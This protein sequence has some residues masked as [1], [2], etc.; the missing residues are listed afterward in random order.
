MYTYTE[1]SVT[2]IHNK[3]WGLNSVVVPSQRV[4]LDE[5]W[6]TTEH[7]FKTE[8]QKYAFEVYWEEYMI[9]GE[10]LIPGEWNYCCVDGKF[11]HLEKTKSAGFID[12][13]ESF[14]YTLIY[15][16]WQNDWLTNNVRL[17]GTINLT[18]DKELVKQHL[19]QT[20]PLISN[21]NNFRYLNGIKKETEPTSVILPDELSKWV[22][23]SK[24]SSY[25]YLLINDELK[26]LNLGEP[27]RDKLIIPLLYR[28][29][30]KYDWKWVIVR[31]L[32]GLERKTI[33]VYDVDQSNSLRRTLEVKFNTN[34][35]YT[36][37]TV[38]NKVFNYAKTL[39]ESKYIDEIDLSGFTDL[40]QLS[41]TTLSPLYSSIENTPRFS[42]RGLCEK[43]RSRL[44]WDKELIPQMEEIVTRVFSEGLGDLIN[45]EVDNTK[46]KLFKN[47]TITPIKRDITWFDSER[48]LEV[49][50][51]EWFFRFDSLIPY[52]KFYRNFIF[53]QDSRKDTDM[54]MIVGTRNI[55]EDVTRRSSGMVYRDPTTKTLFNHWI[56]GTLTGMDKH[57]NKVVDSNFSSWIIGYVNRSSDRSRSNVV[58]FGVYI[59]NTNGGEDFQS[60]IRLDPFKYQVLCKTKGV[61]LVLP[62]HAYKFIEENNEE[63]EVLDFTRTDWFND[64]SVMLI[65]DYERKTHVLS[66]NHQCSTI[67]TEEFN[68]FF[69]QQDDLNPLKGNP[70][71]PYIT[72][73][74]F[75]INES[76]A[77]ISKGGDLINVW[78]NLH[79][80][81]PVNEI[82]PVSSLYH[83]L[84]G[85][86]CVKYKMYHSN[87]SGKNSCSYNEYWS[88]S[89]ESPYKARSGI[90]YFS[91]A[92]VHK[93]G[94]KWIQYQIELTLPYTEGL[95]QLLDK[96]KDLHDY[97]VSW[98]V[99]NSTEGK[100]ANHPNPLIWKEGRVQRMQAGDLVSI[101][102]KDIVSIW[103]NPSNHNKWVTERELI[104]FADR[105]NLNVQYL[106]SKP[107]DIANELLQAFYQGSN[108]YWPN[109]ADTHYSVI[110]LRVYSDTT[111]NNNLRSYDGYPQLSTGMVRPHE[112]FNYLC[113]Y[114][115]NVEFDENRFGFSNNYTPFRFRSNDYF[116]MVIPD[117][118]QNSSNSVPIYSYREPINSLS[119]ESNIAFLVNGGWFDKSDKNRLMYGGWW[120]SNNHSED[121]WRDANLMNNRM[122]KWVNEPDVFFEELEQKQIKSDRTDN[123]TMLKSSYRYYSNG[124]QQLNISSLDDDIPPFMVKYLDPDSTLCQPL[125]SWKTSTATSNNARLNELREKLISTITTLKTM[126]S[127]QNTWFALEGTDWCVSL[128]L[129]IDSEVSWDFELFT[130]KPQLIKSRSTDNWNFLNHRE[131]DVDVLINTSNE[132]T[133]YGKRIMLKSRYV[134]NND[135]LELGLKVTPLPDHK[136]TI[137]SSWFK[138]EMKTQDQDL[139]RDIVEIPKEQVKTVDISAYEREELL[140]R[141]DLKAT[142]R[143]SEAQLLELN[144]ERF[145][146]KDSYELSENVRRFGHRS[147]MATADIIFGSMKASYVLEGGGSM[148]SGAEQ[149]TKGVVNL[150]DSVQEFSNAEKERR[151][152]FGIGVRE[153]DIKGARM[154]KQHETN[155]SNDIERLWQMSSKIQYPQMTSGLIYKQFNAS[156]GLSDVYITQYYPSGKLLKYIKDYYKEYGY[157]ILVRDFPC[158]GIESIK[159]HLRYI[160]IF[161]NE[162]SSQRVRA[163]IEARALN[164]IFVSDEQL[165]W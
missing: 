86:Y 52:Q 66:M 163:L 141:I 150:L 38:E 117:N 104:N 41:P 91:L 14:Y 136:Q 102:S 93:D 87:C 63:S 81:D 73:E 4:I 100:G 164:G 16:D 118:Y 82:N 99:V 119:R 128:K 57:D 158:I 58:D 64:I 18:G 12:G 24:L 98:K 110:P 151:A 35:L 145:K 47:V 127:T 152:R 26:K 115:F 46:Q 39:V 7:L 70:I 61:Q 6:H 79:S 107:Y 105:V 106:T 135:T 13:Q 124:W 48:N 74:L 83:F 122:K 80:N 15:D 131:E 22:K 123:P 28:T 147:A 157:E 111:G 37:S 155:R 55:V 76:S 137:S 2:Y 10:V 54:S 90:S 36:V 108:R 92:R 69:S 19:V 103:L 78:R 68:F 17:S 129:N 125:H 114:R 25:D 67:K 56:N 3:F 95:I 159:R 9:S 88:N 165:F 109:T 84:H 45:R 133:I 65:P 142:E 44:G 53:S 72:T 139:I 149:A 130:T 113:Y 94:D 144:R 8:E 50:N 162:H 59:A 34:E 21:V 120:F 29:T 116:V 5:N 11:F 121:G 160:N 27:N 30:P 20:T 146:V 161:K 112:G 89:D 49:R 62:V 1:F 153:F 97:I 42:L 143:E 101:G 31:S 77:S 132:V 60:W 40:V 43:L 156:E 154:L 140:R 138:V 96:Y 51:P 33:G 148:L 126:L 75:D 71:I 85:T 32:K 23:P 134:S